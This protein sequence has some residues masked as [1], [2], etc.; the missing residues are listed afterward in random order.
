MT[1]RDSAALSSLSMWCDVMSC[2]S[3]SASDTLPVTSC[4]LGYLSGTM[5]HDT[6]LPLLL[7]PPSLT[8]FFIIF[9]TPLLSIHHR[10]R[11]SGFVTHGPASQAG[12]EEFNRLSERLVQVCSSPSLYPSSHPLPPFLLLTPP[13]FPPGTQA[14]TRAVQMSTMS[15]KSFAQSARTIAYLEG[16][17]GRLK[18]MLDHFRCVYVRLICLF[19]PRVIDGSRV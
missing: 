11:D 10:E 19:M 4:P 15:A 8:L 1:I 9:L 12:N 18:T 5:L 3:A 17:C 2:A 13:P 16:E 7:S 14:E 6:R